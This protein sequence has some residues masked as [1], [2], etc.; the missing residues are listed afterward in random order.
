ML[1]LTTVAVVDCSIPINSVYPLT[2]VFLIVSLVLFNGAAEAGPAAPLWRS[3]ALVFGIGAA[4][5]N[6][7]GLVIWPIL[8]WLGWRGR[9]GMGWLVAVAVIGVGFTALYLH[10][11]PHGTPLQAELDSGL[12][13]PGHLRKMADYLLAYL[14]LPLSRSPGLAVPSR[15]FGAALLVAGS[16][17]CVWFGLVSR[18]NGRLERFAVALILVTFGSALLAVLGR[19]D[20]EAEVKIPVRYAVM[21]APLHVGLFI[22]ALSWIARRVTSL[23]WRTVT[24]AAGASFALVMLVQQVAAGRAAVT[25]TDAM[26][27]R[28]TAFYAGDRAAATVAAVYPDPVRAEMLAGKL[29][30]RGLVP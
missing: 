9:T 16:A 20:L 27:A 1:M 29:R 19:T 18:R 13:A 23:R 22:L 12:F 24:L 17:C 2:L 14:G 15:V 26:R 7:V 28:I 8:L 6:G 30:E 11:M 25:V 21:V 5:G 4:F 3:A 10:G